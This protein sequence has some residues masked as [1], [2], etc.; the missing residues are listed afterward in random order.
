MGRPMRS[1]QPWYFFLDHDFIRISFPIFENGLSFVF[2][3]KGAL[4]IQII[5][6]LPWD[7]LLCL[8]LTCVISEGVRNLNA[9]RYSF[10]E[11][12]PDK[13]LILYLVAAWV[14][15]ETGVS[16]CCGHNF[17]CMFWFEINVFL[18]YTLPG[19]YIIL[20]GLLGDFSFIILLNTLFNSGAPIGNNFCRWILFIFSNSKI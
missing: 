20:L 6:R 11:A 9:T 1:S 16:F 19:D 7:F 8:S 13:I 5:V 18:N 12:Y 2:W 10:N 15:N 4:L 17:V 3:I 14:K